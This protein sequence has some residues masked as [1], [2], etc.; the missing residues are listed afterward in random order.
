ME[1]CQPITRLKYN[2]DDDDNN[3]ILNLPSR[4]KYLFISLNLPNRPA[5]E[6]HAY[7]FY[8]NVTNV[9][10]TFMH[11]PLEA[12]VKKLVYDARMQIL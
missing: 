2:D 10:H 5:D 7:W 12:G 9:T 3:N 11:K 1:S 8:Y 4:F 6:I